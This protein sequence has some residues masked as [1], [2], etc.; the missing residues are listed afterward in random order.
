M[1]LL[2]NHACYSDKQRK[3]YNNK[4]T[5]TGIFKYKNSTVKFKCSDEHLNSC[6][7]VYSIL[8][9]LIN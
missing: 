8:T 2:I 6:L 5:T 3:H 4:V 9:C 1:H 7:I